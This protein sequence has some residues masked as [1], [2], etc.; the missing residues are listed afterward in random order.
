MNLII[1]DK[2]KAG[3]EIRI[4][5]PASSLKSR[6]ASIKNAALKRLQSFGFKVTFGK[7]VLEKNILQSSSIESRVRDLHE[8]FADKKVKAILP[9]AGGYS[10]NQLLDHLNYDLIRKNPKILCG[11]SDITALGNAIY[12]KTG[13]M[14]YS[15]PNFLNFGM[16]KGFEYTE[17]YFLKCLTENAAFKINTSSKWADDAWWK[18]QKK[19]HFTK[20]PGMKPVNPGRAEGIIVGGNLCSFNL[21]Q[22]TQYMPSLKNTILFIEDDDL[23]GSQFAPE[24][25]RNLW[26][27]M[28][29][30]GFKSVKGIVFGRFQIKEKMNEKKLRHIVSSAR[31]LKR[32][33]V[34]SGADFGHTTPVFTFPIGGTAK[35]SSSESGCSIEIVRH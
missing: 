32:I 24:F 7:H 1:P 4:V 8:A 26:S 5:A 33:P 35:I 19:R 20:N 16:E 30:P 15:G 18:N 13:L 11:F 22:G 29:Q 14:T 31:Q 3:D 34:L 10:S 23:V 21:L 25:E 12:A 6:K 9:V 2:L 27:L 17:E 28:Q